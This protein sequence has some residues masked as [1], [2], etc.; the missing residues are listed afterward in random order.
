VRVQGWEA[1][2]N[3]TK[4]LYKAHRV[5][6]CEFLYVDVPRVYMVESSLVAVIRS[7]GIT[8]QNY[9]ELVK[10]LIDIKSHSSYIPVFVLKT[11]VESGLLITCVFACV[12]TRDEAIGCV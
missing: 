6:K 11:Q 9:V 8:L 4:F 7:N 5:I 10:N 3:L 2:R 1:G 12:F